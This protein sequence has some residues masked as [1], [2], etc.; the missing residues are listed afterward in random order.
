MI[1]DGGMSAPFLLQGPAGSEPVDV[2]EKRHD[3]SLLLVAE[4]TLI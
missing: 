2:R 3:R 1:L 4:A